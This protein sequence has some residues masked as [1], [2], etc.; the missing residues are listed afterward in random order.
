MANNAR[1]P[2]ENKEPW[3]TL[4]G[5][6]SAKAV[7]SAVED[8]NT[9]QAYREAD[10]LNAMRYYGGLEYLG[11]G[12][13]DYSR[14]GSPTGKIALNV[15]KSC[16]D[17]AQAKI[18]KN[19]ILP[20][21]VT[22]DGDYDLRRRVDKLNLFGEGLF[23]SVKYHKKAPL[24]FRD[25]AIFGTGFLKWYAEHNPYDPALSCVRA[26]RVF[27]NNIK[28]DAADAINGAPRTIYEE[29]VM[30]RDVAA[31]VW[32]KHKDAI[33]EAP[34]VDDAFINM[35][36]PHSDL[37][38]V[39]ESW[40]LPSMP[41]AND[42]KHFL[43]VPGASFLDKDASKWE[44]E[45]FPFAVF[46]WNDP[47]LGYFG[48]GIAAELCD[49]QYEINF[50][51]Q[52]I[53][54]AFRLLGAPCIFVERTSEFPLEQLSNV[55]GNVYTYTGTTPTVAAFQTV[56][57]E[58]FA[59]LD[60][61]YSRAFEIVGISQLSAQSKKPAGL[62]SG[63]ALATYNDIETERFMITGQDYEQLGVDSFNLG[64]EAAKEIADRNG[65]HFATRVSGR[66]NGRRF[67]E[68]I[69]WADADVEI[70][71]YDVQVFPVSSL[72]SEPAGRLAA[73]ERRIKMGLMTPEDALDQMDLPDTEAA[74][75][76]ALA[77][78]WDLEETFWRFL[79]AP[80]DRAGYSP[81]EPQQDL[82][83]GLRLGQIRYLQAKNAGVP[84]DRLELVRMWM[85]DAQALMGQ[86]EPQQPAGPED[87]AVPAP[88][89]EMP[90]AGLP[91]GAPPPASPMGIPPA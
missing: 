58:V 91:P 19:K 20:K 5:E 11:I 66:R 68:K 21:A 4:T 51:L 49:I 50:L 85:A 2:A 62:D 67:L 23:H 27:P 34:A 10:N 88:G 82:K 52:R 40:H 35:N 9:N 72:P 64:I 16:V 6:E 90:P 17:T 54:E 33:M 79:N 74:N 7:F 83:L 44:R 32:K 63:E 69:D 38:R 3:W 12:I 87:G 53:Q 39:V 18:A 28:I 25:G 37:I 47:L 57:P 45:H 1:A 81:P 31:R 43:G 41:G 77:A 30:A 22:N 15:I 71:D 61:L 59:H 55:V 46:R 60:R 73:I 89:T 26:E 70:D 76:L 84:D 65:G 13:G 42:G 8:I 29:L 36:I 48:T 75:S 14:V 86:Q 78:R 24:I 80:D 56:H